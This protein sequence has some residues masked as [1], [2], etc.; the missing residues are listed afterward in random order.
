MRTDESLIPKHGGY[1]KLKSFRVAQLIY[2]VTVRFCERCVDRRS[3]TRDHMV[4]AA[5]SGVQN[6]AEGSQASGTSKR[7]ELKLTN[8]AQAS[9]EELRLDYQDFLRQR[10][11]P[12]RPPDHETLMR[13]KGKRCAAVEEVRAWV[14]DEHRR[15]RADTEQQGQAVRPVS[16][17]GGRCQSVSSSAL[18]ANAALS[19]L[20][21]C[22]YLLDRQLSAQ[23]QA[24][25]NEGG[26]TERLYRTRQQMRRAAKP[27]P[28]CGRPALA[29]SAA[30]GGSK[31]GTARRD[32]HGCH[33]QEGHA[34]AHGGCG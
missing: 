14:E 2:D 13:F 11:L 7:T 17:D 30:R 26:F 10:G 16:V 34:V 25:E 3:R 4:Q 32:R 5:R 27:P 31:I 23:A 29:F 28:L 19:L 8:V 24:F 33:G 1:C 6:I 21:L 20:N 9:L 12:E 18:V 15:A 22:C